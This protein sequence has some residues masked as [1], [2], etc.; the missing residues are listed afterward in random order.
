MHDHFGIDDDV[1]VG[2]KVNEWAIRDRSGCWRWVAGSGG[3]HQPGLLLHLWPSSRVPHGLS[4]PLGS[5][6]TYIDQPCATDTHRHPRW[7]HET[8]VPLIL[9]QK[10]LWHTSVLMMPGDMAWHALWNPRPDTDSAV[11]NLEDRLEERGKRFYTN[12]LFLLLYHCSSWMISHSWCHCR[13]PKLR[14]VYCCGV[15]KKR[16][17]KDM[18]EMALCSP[19]PWD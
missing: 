9:L 2:E 17:W 14:N 6:G 16:T 11:H 13:Q 8:V 15:G 4:S 1:C 3:L 5:A 12:L 10:L 19:W 18:H 7:R